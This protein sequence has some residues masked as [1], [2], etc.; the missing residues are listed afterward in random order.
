MWVDSRQGVT[1][2]FY[3]RLFDRGI[4]VQCLA[5][6]IRERNRVEVEQRQVIDIGVCQIL[7]GCIVEVVQVYYQYARIFQRFLVVKIK[8]A[9]NDLSVVAQYF[10]IVEFRYYRFSN[11]AL[12]GFIFIYSFIFILSRSRFSTIKQLSRLKELNICEF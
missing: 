4:I 8:V 10:L 1:G 9:Q 3:F 11:N 7:R 12:N 6:Q 5:L 2:G